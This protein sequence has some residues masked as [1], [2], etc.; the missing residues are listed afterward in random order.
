MAVG[1]TIARRMD[2]AEHDCFGNARCLDRPSVEF[3]RFGA[4]ATVGI[5]GCEH[6]IEPECDWSK[7]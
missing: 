7:R 4:N 1:L 2:G 5:G 3:G 6:Y